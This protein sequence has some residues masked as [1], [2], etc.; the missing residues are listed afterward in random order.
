MPSGHI[1]K[2]KRFSHIYIE[3]SISDTAACNA[4]LAKFPHSLVIPIDSYKQI[5]NRPRQNPIAQHAYQSLILAKAE[6]NLIYPGAP[7]C[8]DFGNH[9][10]HYTSTAMN[11]VYSCDYCYLKGMYPSGHLVVFL[12]IEDVFAEVEK[13]LQEHPVYLSISYDTDLLALEPISGQLDQWYRFTKEHPNLLLEVR[14]KCANTEFFK[15][16]PGNEQMIFA[17]TL[18]PQEV[19]A[20]CE[21][22]TPSLEQRVNAAK[23]A[24]ETGYPVRFCFDP[25]IYTRN[26]KEQYANLLDWL[27][28]VFPLALL[29]DASIGSFRISST[30]LKQMRRHMPDTPVVWYPYELDG[31]YYAYPADLSKEMEEYLGKLLYK[32]LPEEKIFFWRES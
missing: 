25:M 15:T 16:H 23:T 3:K 7:V 12:N 4:I 6:G 9:Y 32:Y 17:W 21:K 18:S 19:I 13:L 28:E 10:F 2:S 20:T 5:F 29:H 8:Q 22:E 26:W 27:G 14:T 1:S 11:C 31:G 24:L 30:Y